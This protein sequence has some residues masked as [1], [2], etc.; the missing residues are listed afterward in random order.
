MES[1]DVAGHGVPGLNGLPER[2]PGEA[3][4]RIDST[5]RRSGWAFVADLDGEDARHD[6]PA[7]A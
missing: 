2:V 7:S 1:H 4:R 5:D 3:K 6:L